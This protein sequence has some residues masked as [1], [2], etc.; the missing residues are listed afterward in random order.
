MLKYL[1]RKNVLLHYF[2]LLHSMSALL[3]YLMTLRISVY[4]CLHQGI[5]VQCYDYLL[6]DL[7][8]NISALLCKRNSSV[9]MPLYP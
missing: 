7:H 2:I 6:A 3:E 4:Q 8:N 1:L 5:N 9:A